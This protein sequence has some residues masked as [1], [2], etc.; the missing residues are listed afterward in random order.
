MVQ[1]TKS[2]TINR[3]R[4]EVYDFWRD[5]QNLPRFM[6]HLESV[7]AGP[8]PRSHWVATGPAGTT[9]S[10]D[11]EIVEDRPGELLAWRSIDGATV[12]NAGVVLFDDAPGDRGTEL[13]VEVRYDPPG[14]TA[15][16]T[17]AKLFGE[18]PGQQLR[19]DLRRFKQVLE[20]GEVVLSDGSREGAGQGYWKQR[21]AQP[22]GGQEAS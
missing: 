11:A 14:G 12:P 22:L 8:G 20:T 10:W 1:V 17:V 18:E 5:L 2:V 21:P 4:Q 6:Q 7:T 13:R 16:A 19:D 9:V 3:P 15:G